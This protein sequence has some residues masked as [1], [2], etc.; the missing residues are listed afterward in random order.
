M[1]R[2]TATVWCLAREGRSGFARSDAGLS[3]A[4]AG[5]V[6]GAAGGLAGSTSSK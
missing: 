3:L 2:T 6:A 1:R 4:P 5:A